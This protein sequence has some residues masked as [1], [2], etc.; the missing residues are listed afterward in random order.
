[1][2]SRQALPNPEKPPGIIR[3]KNPTFTSLKPDFKQNPYSKM[4]RP[5]STMFAAP[6]KSAFSGLRPFTASAVRH[7]ASLKSISDGSNSTS[8]TSPSSSLEVHS[9]APSTSPPLAP[10]VRMRST[11]STAPS[12]RLIGRALADVKKQDDEAVRLLFPLVNVEFFPASTAAC[13]DFD[14]ITVR[15]YN[16]HT[17]S[18]YQATEGRVY[19][20]KD[21]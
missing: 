11:H 20:R 19:Y 8:E 15:V 14:K 10:P 7:Q 17:D 1:M 12:H 6:T 16:S 9:Q 5:K 2:S 4:S 13:R 18:A 3:E 21:R